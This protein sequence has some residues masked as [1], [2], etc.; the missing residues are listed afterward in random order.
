MERGAPDG[1]TGTPRRLGSIMD[2]NVS[3]T[4]AGSLAWTAGEITPCC[5]REVSG[6][7]K[8]LCPP[9]PCSDCE[10]KDVP[11]LRP[12]SAAKAPLPSVVAV[13]PPAAV[14]RCMLSRDEADETDGGGS[15]SM[16]KK[17]S[18]FSEGVILVWSG[19]VAFGGGWGRYR[20][21]HE[22]SSVGSG[23]GST[24]WVLDKD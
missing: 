19:R 8:L 11:K 7:P 12:V 17:M 15:P 21:E 10:C 18:C 13:L 2:G 22:F 24:E 20:V 23:K 4:P 16:S 6:P 1:R 3:G 9:S 5:I 14:K